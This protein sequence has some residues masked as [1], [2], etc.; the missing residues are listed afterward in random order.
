MRPAGTRRG[1]P[2][3]YQ[4]AARST[5]RAV[6]G[7]DNRRRSRR[8]SPVAAIAGPARYT[9][10]HASAPRRH[11]RPRHRHARL[12]RPGRRR[13]STAS[14]CSCAA[15]CPATACRAEVTQA[16]AVGYA[17]GAPRSSSSPPP[18][19]ASPPRCDHAARR[20]AAAS[21][22]PSTTPPSS[23][24]SSI[25]WS[26]R[27]PASAHLDGLRARAH[28]RHGRPLALPQQDG[29]LV[30]AGR[31]RRA[32]PRPAPPRLVARHRRRRP[33][34]MLALG[35][36]E[37]RARQAVAD[38]LPRP[39]PAALLAASDHDGLLRHL[40]VR[41]GLRQRRPA[42]QPLRHRALPRGARARRARRRRAALHARSP[43]P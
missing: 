4:L 43:S 1:P 35:A 40:V 31:R 9:G 3:L 10:P 42:A 30:R 6:R 11:A 15:P 29:V 36:H 20:A 24:S 19:A 39:R 28:P 32:A 41:E 8:R 21:G 25:R 38:R 12:R 18:R 14:S 17:R 7:V 16:Q 33:T 23:S 13:A 34:A 22:R 2:R 5:A 27:W 37:P 26:S